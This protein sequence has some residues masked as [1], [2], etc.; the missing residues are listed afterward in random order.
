[1]SSNPFESRDLHTILR[2]PVISWSSFQAFRDYDKEDWHKRYVLGIRGPSNPAMEAGRAVGERLATDP[3]YLPQV[4]RPE[5]FEQELRGKLGKISLVG[6]VDGWSPSVPAILEYKTTQNKNKWN[7]ESVALHGQLDFYCLLVWLNFK[8]PPEKLSISLTAIL[9]KESGSFALD[10][11]G[12]VVVVP[13]KRTM[14]QILRFAG[15][16]KAVHKEMLQYVE[17]CDKMNGLT[18]KQ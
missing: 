17:T 16:I 4:P 7:K 6:H 11:T 14:A 9:L 5:I 13:T 10:P 1:M 3:T 2:F 8:I 12:E 15:E 18:I